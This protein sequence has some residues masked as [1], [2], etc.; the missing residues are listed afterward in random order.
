MVNLYLYFHGFDVSSVHSHTGGCS[1][2]IFH[3]LPTVIC[4]DQTELLKNVVIHLADVIIVIALKSEENE[5]IS[6]CTIYMKYCLGAYRFGRR[7]D[8]DG[9]WSRLN[10]VDPF[11]LKEEILEW[12]FHK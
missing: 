7:G 11:V 5:S 12:I 1:M 3:F 4:L 2:W 10:K 6:Y 9:G 8:A